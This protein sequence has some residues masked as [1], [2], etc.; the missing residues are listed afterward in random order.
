MLTSNR[1]RAVLKSTIAIVALAALGPH[2][3]RLAI[4]GKPG[5]GGTTTPAYT[6]TNLGG[7]SAFGT[8]LD[9][10]ARGIT[11]PDAFGVVHVAGYSRVAGDGSTMP[12]DAYVWS[13]SQTGAYL[14]T[15]DLGTLSPPNY[16]YAYS[17][18]ANA[19]NNSGGVVGRI[20]DGFAFVSFPGI[21]A[22]T[23]MYRLPFSAFVGASPYVAAAV[24]NP[25]ADG[26]FSI[27]GDVVDA[28]RIDHGLLWQVSGPDLNGYHTISAPID[29]GA[30]VPTA[31]N[32]SGVMVGRQAGVPAMATLANGVT[33]LRVFAG[34]TAGSA[35]GINNLGDVVGWSN[36]SSGATQAIVWSHASAWSPVALKKLHNNLGCKAYDINE[37]GQIVG[38]SYTNS[39]LHAGVLWEN[40][41]VY[42]L[43][44]LAGVANGKPSVTWAT[45][46]NDIGQICGVAN[47]EAGVIDDRAVVLTRKP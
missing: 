9:T 19:I 37:Q 47:V 7:F 30:F 23:G 20:D 14:A 2:A 32:D 35:L 18:Y 1:Y 5:G 41:S 27:V 3:I 25:G 17:S 36:P 6:L 34:D 45:S 28:N 42:D 24:N 15:S 38:F 21:G 10:Q 22:G 8:F 33:L 26:S 40:G 43:N 13:V 4:A 46:I 29:L 31:I 39:S 44:A 16:P 12:W 11:N